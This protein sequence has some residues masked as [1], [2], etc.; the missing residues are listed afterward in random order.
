MGKNN[1]LVLCPV[2]SPYPGGGA[3][4]FPLLVQALSNTYSERKIYVL[5]E[6]NS[7][8]KMVSSEGNVVLYRILVKRDTKQN[9]TFLYKMLTYLITYVQIAFVVLFLS[10]Y[11]S[12]SVVHYTRYITYQMSFLMSILKLFGKKIVLDVRTNAPSISIY[13]KLYAVDYIFSNSFGVYAE[14]DQFERLKKY[15]RHMTN[16]VALPSMVDN[17]ILLR[18][19]NKLDS[20]LL[21]AC[22][23]LF[24]GQIGY[25]KSIIETIEGYLE[26]KNKF[27][28][29][30][31]KFLVIVGPNKIGREFLDI[32]DS[33]PDEII[34]F[35]AIEHDKLMCVIQNA[36][37]ILQPSRLEGIP[38]VTLESL[39]L[40]KKVLFPPSIVELRG[41]LN[42]LFTVNKINKHEISNAIDRIVNTDRKIVYDV[43][44]HSPENAMAIM[45]KFYS[46]NVLLK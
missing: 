9:P 18:T 5:T 8:C 39:A 16:P 2:Y 43:N 41:E 26:Y 25:R 46:E 38:R 35:P 19:L 10:F 6:W 21:S 13:D 31:V 3:S 22:Y 11:R 15:N 42:D 14:I 32:L 37:A 7:E 23:L 33:K 17:E 36:V 29:S 44:V 45:M 1:I 27:P 34:Y 28:G 40:N 12:V 30:H 4:Y 20:K 24:V